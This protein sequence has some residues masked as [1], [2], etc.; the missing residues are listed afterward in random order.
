MGKLTTDPRTPGSP[1]KGSGWGGQAA[2][3]S[4]PRHDCWGDGVVGELKCLMTQFQLFYFRESAE[5]GSGA[6][7]P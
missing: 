7:L 2:S 1:V 6:G 5:A 4:P 3:F